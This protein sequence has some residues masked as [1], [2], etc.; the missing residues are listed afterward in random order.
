MCGILGLIE[1][2]GYSVTHKK[3]R[4]LTD[5]LFVLAES[6]GKEA[7][8]FATKMGAGLTVYKTNQSIRYLVKSA[9]Y[10]KT[11][12]QNQAIKIIGHSRLVTDGRASVNINN[13]PFVKHGI[14]GVHNGII[15]NKDQIWEKY[16][17]ENR[18]SELDSEL[19]PTLL[20]HFFKEGD[21][22][23]TSL[24]KMYGEFYGMTTIALFFEAT[25]HLL[26]ATN[27]G[28]LYYLPSRDHSV[29]IFSSESIMLK[30]AV[31]QANLNA[32]FDTEEIVHMTPGRACSVN[33]S[34]LKIE[35]IDFQN[36]ETFSDWNVSEKGVINDISE[37]DKHS[38]HN[39]VKIEKEFA[40]NQEFTTFFREC[41]N[42]ITDLT[43]C[44][45]CVLPKT[46]PFID[47]DEE[48]TCN[49]CRS[50]HKLKFKGADIFEKR[51]ENHRRN[52][53]KPDCIVSFSGGRD[54]CFSLHYIKKVLDLNPIAY[55][56]DWGMVT[57]LARRNQARLCDKLGVEHIYISADIPKKRKNIQRNVLAW[58]KWPNLGTIPLLWQG[59]SSIFTT[60]TS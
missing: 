9:A 32:V 47:Y 18:E 44:N 38:S 26:L 27:N 21:D 19:I 2:A 59:I 24:K 34:S 41:E 14:A 31:Q 43:R 6:R 52:D 36:G 15:V 10:K 23:G 12:G 1:L 13:Q 53:G 45:K 20:S 29:F 16:L 58:L 4:Q 51:M 11:L 25:N 30:K 35:D 39:F 56:Y 50:Y 7:S 33:L 55:S 3:T 54:S 49:F 40:P 28:A 57:D 8:G 17:N 5:R 37:P 42:H 22:I 60:P 48:G 46:F